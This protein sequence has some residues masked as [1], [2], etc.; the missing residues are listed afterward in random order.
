MTG[1]LGVAA[2]VV[3]LGLTASLVPVAAALRAHPLRIAAGTL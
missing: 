3:G 1:F 2:T